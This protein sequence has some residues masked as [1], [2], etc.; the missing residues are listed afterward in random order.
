MSLSLLHKTDLV[1]ASNPVQGTIAVLQSIRV[2]DP[3][4]APE[5]KKCFEGFATFDSVEAAD[6]SVTH[7]FEDTQPHFGT[8]SVQCARSRT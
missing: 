5:V 4:L 8:R 7:S 2:F 6:G 3:L 1:T